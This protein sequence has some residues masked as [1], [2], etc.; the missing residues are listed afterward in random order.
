MSELKPLVLYCKGNLTSAMIRAN[1]LEGATYVNTKYD[2]SIDNIRGTRFSELII[3][4]D[5][6]S[7]EYIHHAKSRVYKEEG[8]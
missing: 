7:D 2:K 8:C 4:D 5:E 1:H 3:L 6:C